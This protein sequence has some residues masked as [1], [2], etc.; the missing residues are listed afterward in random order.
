MNCNILDQRRG[1][2]S[3]PYQ[4][5]WVKDL[6][7]LQLWY[8]SPLRLGFNPLPGNFHVALLQSKKKKKELFKSEYFHYGCTVCEKK[9]AYK[10]L[11]CTDAL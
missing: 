11:K 9:V 1:T 10:E 6:A 5:L 7:L 3:I 4:M 8:M 2:G